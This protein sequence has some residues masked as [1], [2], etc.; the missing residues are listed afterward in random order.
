[1]SIDK[2]SGVNNSLVRGI[3]G[4]QN[5]V[6]PD[7]TKKTIPGASTNEEHLLRGGDKV[8][9]SIE[10]KALHKTLSGLKAEIAKLPDVREEKINQAKA[11]IE[12]GFY[13]RDTV[14]KEVAKS[15]INAGI[16]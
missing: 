3:T 8:E 5:L 2:T 1:M 9:I 12:S 6:K 16:L 10:A 4:N 14:T 7:S 15:I 13:N 11:R